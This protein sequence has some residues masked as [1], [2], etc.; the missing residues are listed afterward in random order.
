MS[1]ENRA[2]EAKENAD[3]YVQSLLDL[4][5]GR[6]PL[7]TMPELPGAVAALV[8]GLDDAQLRRPEKQ[9]K[10]SVI[11]VV[12]HLADTEI[13]WGYRVRKTLADPGTA[14][15]GYDQDAWAR[16]LHYGAANLETAL[17]QLRALRAANLALLTSLTAE[18]WDRAGIHS[19]RGPESVRQIAR[20]VGGHDFV[21]RNQIARIKRAIGA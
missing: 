12:Q 14:I 18:E 15:A 17:A 10:W 20:L 21:H 1:F 4:L 16:S 9:D 5:G 19:E 2:S 11:E 6:D 3:R 7:T 13:V 8:A